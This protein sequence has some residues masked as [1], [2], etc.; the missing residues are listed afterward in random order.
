MKNGWCLG[1][2]YYAFLI[3]DLCKACDPLAHDEGVAV[4]LRIME[5]GDEDVD[6]RQ[7]P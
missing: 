7:T 3:D 4:I 5:V 2:K 6:F 1:C